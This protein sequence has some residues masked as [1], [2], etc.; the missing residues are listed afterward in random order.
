[1]SDKSSFIQSPFAIVAI[2]VYEDCN[3]SVR[4]ILKSDWYLLNNW[5]QLK[6]GHL[7]KNHNSDALKSLYGTNVTV[8]AIVGKNGSGKS[9]LLEILYRMFNN[10]SYII[11]KGTERP[12][13]DELYYHLGIYAEMYFELEGELGCLQ[14]DGS[15]MSLKWNDINENMCANVESNEYTKEADFRLRKNVSRCFGYALVSNYAMM[16]LYPY[17]YASDGED[18]ELL[19]GGNWLNSLYS[20]NDG[21]QACIG[22]EPYKG[23]GKIDLNIQ[24]SLVRS[25][26][27]C[28][29]IESKGRELFDGYSYHK[30]KLKADTLYTSRKVNGREKSEDKWKVILEKDF[31]RRAHRKS[32]I[33]SQIL[34][35]YGLTDLNY[36]DKIINAVAVY[37]VW[38]TLSVVSVYNQFTEYRPIG[39]PDNF[40]RDAAPTYTKFYSKVENEGFPDNFGSHI[41]L[42]QNMCKRLRKD[43][44]HATVKLRQALDFLDY[45]QKRCKVRKDWEWQEVETYDEYMHAVHNDVIPDSYDEII[46]QFPPPIFEPTIYLQRKKQTSGEAS[47]TKGDILYTTL[48]TGERQFLQTISSLIYHIRNVTSI[49]PREGMLHYRNIYLFLDEIEV[50]FHPEYQQRFIDMFITM[51]KNQ[52]LLD[53]CNI[54]ITI[55][56]HSPFVLSDIPRCNILCLEDGWNR[57]DA[58]KGE[59]FA[60]NVYDLLNNQFF[61][62][63]FVG[64]FAYKQIETTIE[65]L[66]AMESNLK[67]NDNAKVQLSDLQELKEYIDIIG[68]RFLKH[69][70]SQRLMALHPDREKYELYKSKEME[71]ELL[72]KELGL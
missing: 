43:K 21:Y 2:K 58:I 36:D 7:E 59:T 23:Y 9:S 17:D 18:E 54:S 27:E 48:S 15:E 1:M 72:R 33:V 46:A 52:K 67:D 70:L 10:L 12:K 47:E 61:L 25:R 31:K 37:A 69:R 24:S 11:T 16:S 45:A 28:M 57:S 29:F 35:G 60:S 5:Y 55:A 41:D 56:T 50:S 14:C 30:I 65:K 68:D 44:S 32:S 34:L 40:K 13:A 19:V 22:I 66:S 38:K 4:K 39:H 49:E 20:K 64:E 42:I 51:L 63:K 3:S 6:D 53:K 71:L 8:Q 26:L 62:N